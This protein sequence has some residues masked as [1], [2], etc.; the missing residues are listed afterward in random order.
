MLRAQLL[1]TF[2][3]RGGTVLQQ[4]CGVMVDLSL[5]NAVDYDGQN[6]VFT[7]NKVWIAL[8]CYLSVNPGQIQTQLA[9]G[10]VH[11]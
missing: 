2:R 1:G 8:D 4:L 5:T 3:D 10:M 6:T 11:G 9:G 7:V